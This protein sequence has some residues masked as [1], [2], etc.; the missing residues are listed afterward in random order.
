MPDS[1][2]RIIVFDLGG[3]MINIASGW[4]SACRFAGVPYRPIELT[5]EKRAEFLRLEH[6]YEMGR[7]STE[8][9]TRG[10]LP[11]TNEQYTPEEMA[12]IYLGVIQGERPGIHDIVAGL[13]AAGYRTACLSNTCVLHWPVLT[14]PALYPGI[15]RLDAQHAS[16]LFGERKPGE[17]IYHCFE[18]A[19]GT[20]PA[21][22]LFFD[23]RPENVQA[24]LDCNWH[25]VP[26][27][28][29]RPSDEQIREAL[30]AHGVECE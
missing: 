1:S 8:E 29:D 23:D 25:A 16:H 14:D 18:A 26:I 3:V 17:A 30:S 5:A 20:A 15:A 11:V 4:E 19:T 12:A 10:V 2:L 28:G 9:F 22:I 7:I 13:Q 27:H 21:E 24:A 6:A